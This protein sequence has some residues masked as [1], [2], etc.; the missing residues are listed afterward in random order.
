MT[1]REA[2]EILAGEMQAYLDDGFSESDPYIVALA[3][4]I[5][6]LGKEV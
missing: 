3:I 4:A 1:T 5:K 6:T 2:I